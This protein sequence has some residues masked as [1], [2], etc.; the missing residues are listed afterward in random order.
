MM[1]KDDRPVPVLASFVYGLKQTRRHLKILLPLSALFFL[2]EALKALGWNGASQALFSEIYKVAAFFFLLWMALGLTKEKQDAQSAM[3]QAEAGFEYLKGNAFK[4]G[5]MGLATLLSLGALVLIYVLTASPGLA[6]FNTG[7]F[8]AFFH[9]LED[10]ALW[11]K[12]RPWIELAW[13]GAVLGWLPYRVFVMFNFFGYIIV[14]EGLNAVQALKRARS[15]SDGSFWGL[16]L[17]YASCGLAHL[18]G[19]SLYVVGAIFTF[20]ITIL[21]TVYV[22]RSLAGT[23]KVDAGGF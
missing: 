19:F 2:P 20:P 8:S 18:A 15:I 3:R 9:G 1:F 4:W 5:A 21:A 6:Y 14:D 10:Y 22:Y 23:R 17:F 16:S 7:S 11:L 13:T 12:G